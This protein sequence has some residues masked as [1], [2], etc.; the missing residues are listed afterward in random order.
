MKRNVKSLV[1]C[2]F[3]A[4]SLVAGLVGCNQKANQKKSAAL[5]IKS[6]KI[7]GQAVDLKTKKLANE[8]ITNFDFEIEADGEISSVDVTIKGKTKNY[9][10]GTPIAAGSLDVKET[11]KTGIKFVIHGDKREDAVVTIAANITAGN[12]DFDELYVGTGQSNEKADLGDVSGNCVVVSTQASAKLTIKTE[13]DVDKVTVNGKEAKKVNAKEYTYDF[14]GLTGSSMNVEVKATALLKNDGI[15]KFKLKKGL[16][17]V[18]VKSIRVN[19]NEVEVS[20]AKSSK[21]LTIEFNDDSPL[22]MGAVPIEV[23][24]EDGFTKVEHKSDLGFIKDTFKKTNDSFSVNAIC[25]ADAAIDGSTANPSVTNVPTNTVT[26]KVEGDKRTP[27]TIT[28]KLIDK[29]A[30]VPQRDYAGIG[31]MDGGLWGAWT[32]SSLADQFRLKFFKKDM[33]VIFKATKGAVTIYNKEGDDWKASLVTS[34][35]KFSVGK[36]DTTPSIK[37]IDLIFA[38][39]KHVAIKAP[40]SMETLGEYGPSFGIWTEK[41]AGIEGVGSVM[42]ATKD[43]I[44]KLLGAG[45]T[46]ELP[47]DKLSTAGMLLFDWGSG[48]K[49]KEATI[50]KYKNDTEVSI[51]A[52]DLDKKIKDIK[53]TNGVLLEDAKGLAEFKTGTKFKYVITV[54][55]DEK[56][57]DGTNQTVEKT[58]TAIFDIKDIK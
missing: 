37:D 54:K 12:I 49:I 33:M 56:K 6:M 46:Y 40:F 32:L 23:E 39:D 14:S 35:A 41:G 45:F 15:Y 43:N 13:Q 5:T 4:L 7:G 18:G 38:A 9:P 21:G 58:V 20:K 1:V 10:A 8:A 27:I 3:A 44:D 25:Y 53:E 19:G 36:F 22:K 47:V 28:L 52:E 50:K 55:F 11:G 29:V 26:F 17:D 31:G 34:Q 30:K 51:P 16:L 48:E 42:G 57:A 2:A 24:F